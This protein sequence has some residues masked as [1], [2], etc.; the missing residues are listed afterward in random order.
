MVGCTI[1]QGITQYKQTLDTGGAMNDLVADTEVFSINLKEMS[2]QELRTFFA[3]MHCRED[4]IHLLMLRNRVIP[5]VTVRE[6]QYVDAFQTMLD[7]HM[8]IK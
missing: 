7:R 6:R 5:P 1:Y 8:P 4:I 2:D 3:G